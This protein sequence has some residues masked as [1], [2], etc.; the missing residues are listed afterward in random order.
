MKIYWPVF[1]YDPEEDVRTCFFSE[2]QLAQE[3]EE[4]N[5]EE[6]SRFIFFDSF[7]QQVLVK[8]SMVHVLEEFRVGPQSLESKEIRRMLEAYYKKPRLPMEFFEPKKKS[9]RFIFF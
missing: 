5:F 1:A 2:E 6:E 4:L 8:I 7:H 3:Y 9:K